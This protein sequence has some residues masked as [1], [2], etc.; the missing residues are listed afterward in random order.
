MTPTQDPRRPALTRPTLSHLTLN[1]IVALYILAVLNRGFWSRVIDLL[2]ADPLQVAAFGLSICA[3]TVL[4]LELL[5]PGRLQKP[6]AALL[7]LV[8]AGASYFELAFGALIDREMVRNI[9]ETTVTE[10]RHLV[11]PDAVLQIALTGILPAA[12]VFWP[13]TTRVRRWNLLWRWPLGV[14]VSLAVLM[15]GFFTYYNGF[16]AVLREHS[17][18]MGSYQP[19]ATV[20]AIY[21]YAKEEWQ[22]A[23]PVARAI[24]TD[25]AK[26]PLLTQAAKPVLLVI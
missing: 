8:A 22:S 18:L 12:L 17:E 10:S 11:T 23:D 24:A 3:L 4:L 14:V 20:A 15:G 25:A 7:I 21:H 1:L 5:G 16:S 2:H 26:G 19:G 9:F 6:V 13:R